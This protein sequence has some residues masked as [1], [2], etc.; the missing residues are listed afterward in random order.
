[1]PGNAID[2]K[3]NVMWKFR[4]NRETAAF[5]EVMSSEKTL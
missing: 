3:D 1:M 4:R 2:V 5:L